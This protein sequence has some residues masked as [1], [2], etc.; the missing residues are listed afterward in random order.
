MKVYKV[1]NILQ[2]LTSACAFSWTR[3]RMG[4]G[5]SGVTEEPL[6]LKYRQQ[7]SMLLP[8][9]I[10]DMCGSSSN[11]KTGCNKNY[12]I[13]I[14]IKPNNTKVIHKNVFH[15]FIT[16]GDT[17]PPFT[18]ESTLLLDVCTHGKYRAHLE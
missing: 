4:G 10:R 11:H 7:Y 9:C 5:A 6:K 2:H 16:H 8:V 17:A 1:N 15:I 18:H 13:S 12:L 3:R 14:R